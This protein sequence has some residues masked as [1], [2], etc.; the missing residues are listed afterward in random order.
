MATYV[1]LFQFTNQGIQ[2]FRDSP[3]RADATAKLIEKFGGKMTSIVWTMGPYD[4]VFTAELPDDDVATAVALE[5][6]SHGDIRTTTLR[7]FD[8]QAYMNLVGKLS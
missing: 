6:C 4:G 2:G 7:G 8:R 3:K 5:V 1:F